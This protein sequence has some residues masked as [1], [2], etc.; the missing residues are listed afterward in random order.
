MQPESSQP[1][2]P[3][4]SQPSPPDQAQ[5]APGDTSEKPKETEE[6]KP[7]P[8]ADRDKSKC[9]VRPAK[10][11][12]VVRHGSTPEPTA[13]LAPGMTP[14]QALRH[15]QATEQLLTSTETNLQQLSRRILNQNQLD[16]VSQIRNYVSGSR[17]A[18]QDGDLLR[19][20]TL[21]FKANLL[22]DDLLKH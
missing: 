3:D 14:D 8:C 22:A 10:P 20:R 1:P 15:R 16:T 18:L 2:K 12:R 21:A 17:S 13:Q 19:A 7:P 6:K 5:P 11:H 9:G 4:H